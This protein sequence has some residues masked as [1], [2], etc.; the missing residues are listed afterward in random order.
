MSTEPVRVSAGP[1]RISAAFVRPTFQGV[2]Q[3]LISP[4]KYSLSSTSN[5]T[6]YGFSI[7][8][9]LRELTV[10]GP[11]HPTGVSETPEPPKRIS[12]CRPAPAA[13][14]ARARRRSSR[15]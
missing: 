13:R 11:Y 15:R 14:R 5:A 9:H 12:R 2:A 6:A 10:K 4:L 1:H 3:D 7:L 8:P